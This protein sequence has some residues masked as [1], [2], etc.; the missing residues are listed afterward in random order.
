MNNQSMWGRVSHW[1]E[2]GDLTPL[3][4]LI[5]VGHYGPVLQAHGENALIAWAIGALMDLLHFRAVRWAF[6][7]PGW[8]A[9]LVAVA[10]TIMAAGYHLRFYNNDLLLALPIPLGIAILAWQATAVKEDYAAQQQ[11]KAEAAQREASAQ[12]QAAK[13]AQAQAADAQAHADAQQLAAERAQQEVVKLQR[14]L[15][16]AQRL[17]ER[18]QALEP[19]AQRWD[20]FMQKAGPLGQ[21]VAQFMAGELDVSAAAELASV[22]P[23]TVKRNAAKLNGAG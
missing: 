6:H 2:N 17:A 18:L 14:E 19:A 23:D 7:K 4:V 11:A 9:G 21:G 13:V 15:K 5:S 16:K 8:M 10:T 1:F 12:Q 20:A 22:H 3:A